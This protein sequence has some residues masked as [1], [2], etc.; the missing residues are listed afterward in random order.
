M[1]MLR[2]RGTRWT[3][4]MSAAVLA[5]L[6]T[7]GTALGSTHYV[8]LSA[9]HT[10]HNAEACFNVTGA[11]SGAVMFTVF[12]AGGAAPIQDAVPLNANFFASSASA[13]VPGIQNL[14]AG[15]EGETVLTRVDYPQGGATVVLEQ[16]SNQG[17]VAL[18]IPSVDKAQGATFIVPI[19][20]LHRGTTV[21]IGNPM[22]SDNA[23]ILRYGQGFEEA[24]RAILAHSAIAVEV[25]QANT[26]L[27]I[28]ATD[29]SL[30]IIV[31]LEIE[32][33]NKTT[34]AF[35]WPQTAL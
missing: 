17:Y 34:V 15:S 26:Q 21:L 28:K 18:G 19:G 10:T 27:K 23:V 16:A 25:T 35:V 5:S 4:L 32:E 33:T 11:D 3:T 1:A 2:T 8:I 14:F 20:D 13:S 9:V 30:P 31:Q 22:G 6:A 12:P 24:P 7:A 29:T